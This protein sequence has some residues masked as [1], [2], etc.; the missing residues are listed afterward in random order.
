MFK[1]DNRG[2]GD[3]TVLGAKRSDL[4]VAGRGGARRPTR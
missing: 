4:D 2:L 1:D 3:W